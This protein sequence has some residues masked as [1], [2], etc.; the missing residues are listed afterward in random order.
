VGVEVA[1]L[2]AGE[3][4]RRLRGEEHRQQAGRPHHAHGRPARRGQ[5]L[6]ETLRGS[7]ERRVGGV[8]EQRERGQ[9]GGDGE[10]VSRQ[11]PAW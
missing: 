1:A 3:I 6:R 9:T 8:V 11:R 2:R 4:A 5:A 10:R 7:R